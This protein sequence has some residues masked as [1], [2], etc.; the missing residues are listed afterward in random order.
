MLASVRFYKVGLL[1]VYS[2]KPVKA[3]DASK[4]FIG[5]GTVQN[6]LAP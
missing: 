5:A 6:D 2:G 4:F 1:P 3:S